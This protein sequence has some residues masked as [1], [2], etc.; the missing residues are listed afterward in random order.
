MRSRLRRLFGVPVLLA[1]PVALGSQPVA[2]SK[3]PPLNPEVVD[4]R[5]NGLHAVKPKELLQSIATDKSHCVTV[6]LKP[7][8]WI[9]KAHYFFKREYLDHAELKR[10]V[11]RV[12]VFY[13]KRGFRETQVDTLVADKGKNAVAVTFNI[14]EGP[15]TIVSAL[16]V[17]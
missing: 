1:L 3:A 4:L 14:V 12:K 7:I 15:P 10:D 17:M 16:D 13:W 6:T 8:C 5:L 2:N 11:L 9:S